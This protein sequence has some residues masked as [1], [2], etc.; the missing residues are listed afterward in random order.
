MQRIGERLRTH[1]RIVNTQ[2]ALRVRRY[3]AYSAYLCLLV[4]LGL[5]LVVHHAMHVVLM[6]VLVL[7]RVRKLVR[8]A[9]AAPV[10]VP[11][12]VYASVGKHPARRTWSQATC[13]CPC[14]CGTL[15]P[16]CVCFAA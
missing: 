16:C 9:T 4:D 10:S 5:V 15:L 2:H 11:V 3:I 12:C 7:M 8:E 6:L 14:L 13:S 1:K